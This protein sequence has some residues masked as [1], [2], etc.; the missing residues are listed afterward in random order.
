MHVDDLVN[1]SIQILKISKKKYWRNFS[2]DNSHLNIGSGYEISI[3][4]LAKTIFK[5]LDYYPK[6][7]FNKK[8]P[9]GM[10]RKIMSNTK[11]KNILKNYKSYNKSI[12][13]KKLENIVNHYH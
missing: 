1:Y 5:I 12:F 4:D 2:Y 13:Y 7:I 3:T 9:N 6:I 11:I 8:K 10:K